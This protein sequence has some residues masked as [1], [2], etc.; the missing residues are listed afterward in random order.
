MSVPM[1]G[2]GDVVGAPV[3]LSL[4][5]GLHMSLGRG[6]SML[7][8]SGTPVLI[9]QGSGEAEIVLNGAQGSGALIMSWGSGKAEGVPKPRAI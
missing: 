2:I 4:A 7:R 1:A 8:G 3:A 5:R 6:R 9:L